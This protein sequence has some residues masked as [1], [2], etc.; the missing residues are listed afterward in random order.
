MEKLT[1][2]EIIQ[3][4][5]GEVIFHGS[6][7]QTINNISTDSR[8]I[9]NTD[10]F[11][12]LVGDKFDGHNYINNVIQKGVQ[13][14]VFNKNR[15][16]INEYDL[17]NH[18]VWLIA[19]DDTLQAYQKLAKHYLKKIN[20]IKIGITGSNGKTTTKEILKSI[21]STQYNVI[22]NEGNLNNQIGV[23]KTV[24]TID[25]SHE[26]AII[27]MG[28]GKIGDISSLA[29]IIEPDIAIIT[30]IGQAHTEFLGG[31]EGVAQEKKSLLLEM[32]KSGTAILNEEDPFFQFLK[33]NINIKINSF[34]LNN[35]SHIKIIDNLGMD[36][37]ILNV[38]GQRCHYKLGGQ[39]NL[40]NL[41]YAI[42]VAELLSINLSNLINGI[43][44]IKSFKMRSEI[45]KGKYI[46]IKDC[47]NAN[48]SSM[49]AGLEYLNSIKSNGKK[50]C[51]LGDMLELGQDSAKLHKEIG[52]YI[53]KI[54][55]DY[56]FTLGNFSLEIAE[57]AK[58]SGFNESN[59]FSYQNHHSLTEHIKKMIHQNDIIYLKASRG[60]ELEKV[61]QQIELESIP[62]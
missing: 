41:H 45:T 15:N 21:L 39:H 29:Q 32:S 2:E 47:Y 55:I 62:Q 17:Y 60:L 44:N 52:K 10:L 51:V 49:K 11:I 20:T 58:E 56:L 9:Q 24:F 54:N 5:N 26:I 1:I 4:T 8:T 46:L 33:E 12:P 25:K 3:F 35:N 43:E 40:V 42:L 36:G 57:G 37:Y 7:N 61:A 30:S 31:L 48:P 50:F 27:E 13:A 34:S 23:P 6:K 19:V 18:P 22:A 53:P 38:S 28:T 59:I 16:L 14:I